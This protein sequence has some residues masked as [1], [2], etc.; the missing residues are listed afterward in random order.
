[1]IG[2]TKCLV[3]DTV[4]QGPHRRYHVHQ[5][6]FKV[7]HFAQQ[8]HNTTQDHLFHTSSIFSNIH[9]GEK[10]DATENIIPLLNEQAKI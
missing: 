4:C 1:M 3:H 9:L 8:V 7:A 6:T 10:K 5:Q 2:L